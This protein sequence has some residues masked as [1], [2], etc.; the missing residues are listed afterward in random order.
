MFVISAIEHILVLSVELHLAD[1]AD[2][3]LSDAV[4]LNHVIEV[5][6]YL[7]VVVHELITTATEIL[8]DFALLHKSLSYFLL[9][10]PLLLD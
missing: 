4:L 3:V 6:I 9:I 2:L 10:T 1:F 7:V 5:I 8:D